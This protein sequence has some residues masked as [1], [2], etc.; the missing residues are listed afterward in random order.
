[1]HHTPGV[2]DKNHV[3]IHDSGTNLQ[4]TAFELLVNPRVGV[5]LRTV[6]LSEMFISNHTAGCTVVLSYI[7]HCSPQRAFV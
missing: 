5:A 1:M 2:S 4:A 7:F 6:V 3:L